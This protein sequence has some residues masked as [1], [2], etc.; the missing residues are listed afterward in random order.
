VI[1]EIRMVRA[2]HDS[3]MTL[4]RYQDRKKPFGGIQLND[5]RR[6]TQVSACLFAE[7]DWRIL[8]LLCEHVFLIV[9]ALPK[10]AVTIELKSI[11]KTTDSF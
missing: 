4:Q 6:F 11:A 7:S 10:T 9:K 2:V 8:K 3:V 5:D 1:D